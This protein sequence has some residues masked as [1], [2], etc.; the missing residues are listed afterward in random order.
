MRLC[1]NYSEA[2]VTVQQVGTHSCG[3]NG[4]KTQKDV[5]FVA[6]HSDRLE[7]L[8]DKHAYEF[9]FN[10][11]PSARSLISRKRFYEQM[12]ETENRTKMF[13]LN[14]YSDEELESNRE[15]Q[16]K[17]SS[18]DVH[19]DKKRLPAECSISSEENNSNSNVPAKWDTISNG[20]LI[21]YTASS[22][23]NQSKVTLIVINLFN[24]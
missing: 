2:T 24:I 11:P 21:I 7:L 20:K 12:D 17:L 5:R 15:D 8:Y 1:A 4:F 13:K 14:N 19:S 6:R 22:V 23:Q 3:F 16:E 18:K 9:E 10:P